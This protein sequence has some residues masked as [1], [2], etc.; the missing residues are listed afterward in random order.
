MRTDYLQEAQDAAN[1]AAFD[2]LARDYRV[3]RQDKGAGR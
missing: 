3:V 2:K 1:K